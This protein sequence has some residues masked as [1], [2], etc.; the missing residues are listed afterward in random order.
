MAELGTGLQMLGEHCAVLSWQIDGLMI[1]LIRKRAAAGLQAFAIAATLLSAIATPVKALT[2]SPTQVEMTAAGQRGR[3]QVTVTN[4]GAQPIP[5]EIALQQMALD[6]AGERKL[7]K[8]EDNFLILP[9]QA[10]IG[11]G[12]TQVFRI[13]WV[14]DPDLAESQ[15]YMLTVNQIPVKLP[16]G[17]S[18]VQIVMSFGVNVNVAPVRGSPQLRLVGTGIAIDKSGARRPTITVEN[19]SKVHALLPQATIAL[20]GGRGW[21]RTLSSAELNQRIGIGLVQPGKRRK[22]TLPVDVPAD[23]QSITASIGFKPAR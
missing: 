20:S 3:A 9:P 1:R 13:Q 15:S 18:G 10:V 7:S 14:G 21:T 22:F 17:K 5:I 11:P 2:V 8:A 4:D 6:E 19:P 16:A 12:A 23:V